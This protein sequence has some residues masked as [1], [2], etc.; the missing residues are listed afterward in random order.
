MQFFVLWLYFSDLSAFLLDSHNQRGLWPMSCNFVK[1]LNFFLIL[2]IASAHL[3]RAVVCS[4]GDSAAS[5]RSLS[6]SASASASVS[7]LSV[8]QLIS[9]GVF[10][11]PSPAAISCGVRTQSLANWGPRAQGKRLLSPVQLLQRADAEP[12]RDSQW[13]GG[14]RGQQG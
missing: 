9:K 1:L 3:L 11:S 13:R 12:S 5:S 10:W 2:L 8:V 14:W 6:L 4:V 7:A